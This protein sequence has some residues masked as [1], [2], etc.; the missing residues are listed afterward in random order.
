MLV[1]LE[2][3]LIEIGDLFQ[4]IAFQ[5]LVGLSQQSLNKLIFNM[6]TLSLSW[7]AYLRDSNP[8][9]RRLFRICETLI[10]VQVVK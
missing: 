2:E 6:V 10:S 1:S 3:T 7:R 8:F 9:L 4:R 5:S